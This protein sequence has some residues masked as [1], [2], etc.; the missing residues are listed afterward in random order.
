[1][2]AV[3]G[4]VREFAEAGFTHVALCQIGGDTQPGFIEWWK[5]DLGP[6]LGAS[7]DPD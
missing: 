2:E 5:R 4:A 7:T 3:V 6:A 1:V